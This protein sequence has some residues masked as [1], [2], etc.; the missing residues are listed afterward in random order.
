MLIGDCEHVY[1]CTGAEPIPGTASKIFLYRWGW[2]CRWLCVEGLLGRISQKIKETTEAHRLPIEGECENEDIAE[3]VKMRMERVFDSVAI[4]WLWNRSQPRVQMGAKDWNFCY[5][6]VLL[7]FSKDSAVSIA[8]AVPP[9]WR[10]W[11]F[12]AARK[13][14]LEFHVWACESTVLGPER[15]CKKKKIVLD[16]EMSAVVTGVTICDFR[17]QQYVCV[18]WWWASGVVQSETS[19]W[20]LW[21]GAGFLLCLWLWVCH[22][23]FLSEKL[24][25]DLRRHRE[26]ERMGLIIVKRIERDP[27]F[28]LV[29]WCFF[30]QRVRAEGWRNAAHSLSPWGLQKL[31]FNRWKVQKIICKT[32]RPE[33]ICS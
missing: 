17:M 16:S 14:G 15:L 26:D 8:V 30:L 11:V 6:R 7:R 27:V 13:C 10:N 5:L 20:R 19:V 24:L 32:G 9:C 23:V 1:A 25:R 21:L 33:S 4:I 29:I 28:V 22:G 12:H 3:P 2:K 31:V 18:F